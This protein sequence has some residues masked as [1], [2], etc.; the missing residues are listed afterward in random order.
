MKALIRDVAILTQNN[1]RDFIEAGFIIID[2]QDIIEVGRMKQCPKELSE[3]EVIEGKGYLVTPGFINAH[4]HIAMSLLRGYAD[5]LPL[6]V[7][8]SEKIWPKEDRLTKED[9]YWG[10][11]LSIIEM[12][13]T[14]T[15]TF[16]DMY[17]FMDTIAQIVQDTGIRA[18]LSTGLMEEKQGLVGLQKNKE[19]FEKWNNKAE[20][21]IKV[22]LGPHAVYTSKP[23]F[24]KEVL[25]LAEET[26]MGIHTHLSETQAE[27]KN[28]VI[29][30]GKTPVQHMQDMGVFQYPVVAAHGVH[31]SDIDMEILKSNQ[32]SIVHN[33]GS[34]LKLGSGIASIPQL[35][36]RGIIVALGTDGASSNNNLDLLEEIRLA[37]L[38]HKG[39]L[40][41]ST[42]IRAEQALD[43][44]TVDGAKALGWTTIGV[45]EKGRKADL[46]MINLKDTRFYPKHN[47]LSHL[48][49]SCNSYQIENVM[50]NGKWIM[51]NRQLQ[52]ID[53]KKVLAQVENIR[54]KLS[55]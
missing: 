16:N 26:G 49:Y 39:F 1:N 8:L 28:C 29:K 38:I 46:N 42:A 9:I 35:L 4:T 23:S 15:T 3:Y 6:E 34:N 25:D 50:V 44:A 13:K 7:W 41:D 43:M 54:I 14:G 53:E 17:M 18:G 20:G 48:V 51:K 45:I 21:R 10:S 12:V 37:A 5:D 52:T 32:V 55:R 36:E 40:Q 31:L 30:Y 24:W 27:V 47:L 22:M 19:L 2:G 33:P 11:L